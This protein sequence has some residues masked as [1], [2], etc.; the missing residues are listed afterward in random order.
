MLNLSPQD[1]PVDLPMDGTSPTSNPGDYQR[2]GW[3]PQP[4]ANPVREPVGP[5]IT[6]LVPMEGP[7]HGGIEV[8]ILGE[9][10][11]PGMVCAFG[12]FQ[13]LTVQTYGPTTIVCVLPP[14]PT[15]G[16]VPVHVV[17]PSGQVVPGQPIYFTYQ[18]ATD[19]K[20]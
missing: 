6:R 1:S 12:A 5:K 10:F 9:N 7:T 16:Q 13:A 20:L 4:P 18:D 11:Y 3:S 14:S 15:A 8:T 2:L 17:D 19:Q